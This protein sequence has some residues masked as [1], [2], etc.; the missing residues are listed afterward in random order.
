MGLGNWL[1]RLFSSTGA[2]D[3][4]AERA[5]YGIPDRGQMELE[6]DRFGSFAENEGPG[7]RRRN[8]KSSSRREI[9]PRNRNSEC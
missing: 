5:E 9:R 2:E 1:R 8:S 6:R 4:T 7:P 3:E